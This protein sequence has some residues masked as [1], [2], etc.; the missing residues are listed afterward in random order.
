MGNLR[1]NFQGKGGP[2]GCFC[3]LAK[4]ARRQ[5]IQLLE[6]ALPT[7]P[8]ALHVTKIR[9]TSTLTV[10]LLKAS[11]VYNVWPPGFDISWEKKSDFFLHWLKIVKKSKMKEKKI[12]NYQNGQNWPK[13]TKI[14][15][16]LATIGRKWQNLSNFSAWVTRP[17]CL[18]DEVNWPPGGP[19]DFQLLQ[20]SS[21]RLPWH[22]C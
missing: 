4:A 14:W 12:K 2:K 1:S 11:T 9:V 8:P 10:F 19:L 20:K 18:K 16:K 22:T 5:V 15:L 17:D 13:T 6:Y 21:H 7:P 3:S